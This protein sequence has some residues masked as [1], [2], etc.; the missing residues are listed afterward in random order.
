MSDVTPDQQ[1]MHDALGILGFD[2]DG[3]RT[4]AAVIAGM[5]SAG[6][7]SYFLISIKE[8]RR[9]HDAAIDEACEHSA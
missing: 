1:A 5:G 3:D 6:F 7:R 9:D 8:A 4:P 2:L